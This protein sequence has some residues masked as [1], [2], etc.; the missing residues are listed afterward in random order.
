ML[1]ILAAY[2]VRNGTIGATYTVQ[3]SVYMKK[4]FCAVG[5]PRSTGATENP[6]ARSL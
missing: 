4:M 2:E 3:C 6:V 5:D 1:A